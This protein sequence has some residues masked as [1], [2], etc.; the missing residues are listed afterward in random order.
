MGLNR[1]SHMIPVD[2]TIEGHRHAFVASVFCDNQPWLRLITTADLLAE[3][4]RRFD[5]AEAEAEADD[6]DE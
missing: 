1:R 3:I 5:E 4:Q 6:E 2:V